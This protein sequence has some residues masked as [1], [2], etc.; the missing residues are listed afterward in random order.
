MR[1]DDDCKVTLLGTG[2]PTPRPKR[3]GLSTLVA[4]SRQTFSGPVVQKSES[5]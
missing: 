1:A 2:V 5:L 3:F 4:T